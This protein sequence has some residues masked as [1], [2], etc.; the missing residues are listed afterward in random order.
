MSHKLEVE[1]IDDQ[2]SQAGHYLSAKTVF[3][4]ALSSSESEGVLLG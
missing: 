2:S 1:L 3:R 4:T